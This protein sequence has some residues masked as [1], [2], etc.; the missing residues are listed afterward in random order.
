MRCGAVALSG[1]DA[2]IER[3]TERGRGSIALEPNS[4]R[5]PNLPGILVGILIFVAAKSYQALGA[6]QVD[7]DFFTHL[8]IGR[9]IV[10]H[11][12]IPTYDVLSWTGRLFHLPYTYQE[13]LFDIGEYSLWHRFGLAGPYLLTAL[14]ASAGVLLTFMLARRRGARPLVALVAAMVAYVAMMASVAP[15]PQMVTF[16]LVVV[17]ALLF[18]Y[19]Q[20][21][22]V[23]P[24]YLLGIQLH[25]GTYPLYLV[26]AGYYALRDRRYLVLPAMAALT[27]LTPSGLGL[28]AYPFKA[29]GSLAGVPIIEAAPVSFGKMPLH[30]IALLLAAIVAIKRPVPWLERLFVLA[31]AGLSLLAMRQLAWFYLLGVPVLLTY[32]PLPTPK[33]APAEEPAAELSAARPAPRA[34]LGR[35]DRVGSL[36]LIACLLIVSVPISARAAL[37]RL[38]ED[39]GFPKQAVAYIKEHRVTRVM[40]RL[41]EGGYLNAHGVPSMV[42]GRIDPFTASSNGGRDIMGPYVDV[43]FA[44]ADARPFLDKYGVQALLVP[45]RSQVA[46]ALADRPEFPV[47]LRDGAFV[48]IEYH[49]D[50]AAK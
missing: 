13:W 24:V 3:G 48:L 42:D 1:A 30:Y 49:P 11:R 12:A 28:V 40:N 43:L 15:R 39:R 8:A 26:V 16:V 5:M 45:A 34:A 33:E 10:E 18:E 4:D 14:L 17:C 23:L 6:I 46:I 19:D 27:V 47:V 29:F 38:N 31:L 21:W 35:V 50:R 36:V 25:G 37:S 20:P 2:R 44:M 7:T 32:L 22:L 41:N 9:W